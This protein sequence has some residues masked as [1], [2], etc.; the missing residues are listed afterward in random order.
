[1]ALVDAAVKLGVVS[2][3]GQDEDSSSS[4]IRIACLLRRKGV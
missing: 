2:A 1:M 3:N 4:T